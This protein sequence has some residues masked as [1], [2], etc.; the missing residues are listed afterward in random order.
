MIA[1]MQK[2]P[3]ILINAFLEHVEITLMALALA[4]ILSFL[5]TAV[6]LFYPK[7]REISVYLLS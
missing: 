6:L 4:V 1:F 2:S 7:L 3:E 5:V